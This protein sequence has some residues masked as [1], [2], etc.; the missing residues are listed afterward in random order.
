[1]LHPKKKEL[2]RAVAHNSSKFE[3]NYIDEDYNEIGLDEISNKGAAH[4]SFPRPSP[5]RSKTLTAE[6]QPS[7][8]A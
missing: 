6:V 5:G 4:L 1:M 8:F 2:V 3:D 7:S